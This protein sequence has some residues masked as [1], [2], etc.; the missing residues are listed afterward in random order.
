MIE[1]FVT[2]FKIPELRRRI[3]FS[4]TLLIVYRIGAH[5]PVPGI[6]SEALAAAMQGFANTLL[7]LY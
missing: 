1:K 2:S 5:E 7:G 6:N 3:F 4:M